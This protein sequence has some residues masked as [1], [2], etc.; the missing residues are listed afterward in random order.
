MKQPKAYEVVERA[1][2]WCRKNPRLP[3]F[4]IRKYARV[5]G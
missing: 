1:I 4:R 3:W 5:G 2:E